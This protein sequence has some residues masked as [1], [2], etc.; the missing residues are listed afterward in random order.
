MFVE[1][2][3]NAFHIV[4][5]W[6]NI[7]IVLLTPVN[8]IR[9][10]PFGTIGRPTFRCCRFF[11]KCMSNTCA[12]RGSAF[13]PHA[14]G[15]ILPYVLTFS[16]RRVVGMLFVIRHAKFFN[17]TGIHCSKRMFFFMVYLKAQ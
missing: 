16:Y 8:I 7:L 6:Y 4:V 5:V 15:D 13:F 17:F 3:G 14:L 11:D 9:R 2:D 1:I 12:L 10:Q